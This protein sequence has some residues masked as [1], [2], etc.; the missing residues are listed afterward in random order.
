MRVHR[1]RFGRKH[2][3][4]IRQAP[5]APCKKAS[6]KL[7]SGFVGTFSSSICCE[8]SLDD[9][10][11]TRMTSRFNPPLSATSTSWRKSEKER[12]N[13]TFR[14]MTRARSVGSFLQA[15]GPLVPTPRYLAL[16]LWFPKLSS[17]IYIHADPP[18]A[19]P[20]IQQPPRNHPPERS[21]GVAVGEI[22]RLTDF[23]IPGYN[24]AMRIPT[25]AVVVVPSQPSLC[26]WNSM[27]IGL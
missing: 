22:E 11:R 3:V 10:P 16:F 4:S 17:R 13:T 18:C 2:E 8:V 6:R 12:R 23:L 19:S 14:P 9:P 21:L 20:V 7:H 15:M 25:A 26:L 1:P 5:A 24:R 27:F